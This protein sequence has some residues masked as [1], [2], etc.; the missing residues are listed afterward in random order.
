MIKQSTFHSCVCMG[1]M[2]IFGN[3]ALSE[4]YCSTGS[5]GEGGGGGREGLKKV[6]VGVGKPVEITRNNSNLRSSAFKRG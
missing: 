1:R 3:R 5:F 4:G 6:G 2:G